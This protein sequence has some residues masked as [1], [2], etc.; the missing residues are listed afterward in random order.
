MLLTGPTRLRELP[1]G[2]K[3]FPYLPYSEVFPHAAAVVHQG[4]IGT[5]ARAMRS[6]RPQVIVPLAFDQPDNAHRTAALGVARAIPL[7]RLTAAKLV[8]ALECVLSK[9]QYEQAATR[10]A[11]ELE[12]VDGA[13]RAAER[14]IAVLA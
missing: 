5:L 14:L 1:P 13:A 10:L 6:G 2:I 8:R 9:P 4:G 3:A 12:A 11:V 7:R